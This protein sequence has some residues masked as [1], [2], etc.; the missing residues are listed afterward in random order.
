[1]SMCEDVLEIDRFGEVPADGAMCDL[2]WSD[3]LYQKD[4]AKEDWLEC[5]W[6]QNRQRKISCEC[7][8]LFFFFP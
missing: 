3:P 4:M 5:R 2:L 6:E 8:R 1:M 7:L